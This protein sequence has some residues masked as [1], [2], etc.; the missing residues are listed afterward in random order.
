MGRFLDSSLGRKIVMALTGLLLTGF[1]VAHLAGNF[2]LFAGKD[3]EAFIKYAKGLHDL[4]PLLVVAELGLVALF[5]VHI[6]MAVRITALNREARPQRYAVKKTFGESTPASASMAV[7]G[8]I[9]L[10]FLV[11]HLLTMRFAG[12][13]QAL[14]GEKLH[15]E[16][17]EVLGS[18]VMALIYLIGSLVVG[19]H[20]AHGFKSLFQSLGV[21]HP[22][23]AAVAKPLGYG[24]AVFFALGFASFPIAGLFGYWKGDM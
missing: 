21:N 6:M 15:T 2:T 23:V 1:L 7:T 11:I 24:L 18:P 17:I 8:S 13:I 22:R 16:V 12:G 5:G 3:G 19:I 20:L 10:G 14:Q 9:V 4:G